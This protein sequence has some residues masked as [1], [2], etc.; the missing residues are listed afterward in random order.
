MA[1]TADEHSSGQP[2]ESVSELVALQRL[3]QSPNR[4]ST[5][6]LPVDDLIQP[7]TASPALPAQDTRTA[8][9][10]NTIDIPR[11]PV[12]P[13]PRGLAPQGPTIV[14]IR[15]PIYVTPLERLGETPEWID[16]P[17]CQRRTRTMVTKE[18]STSTT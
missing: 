10:G 11:H 9:S 7:L 13:L 2:E 1:V 4:T 6:A 18:D 16:C 3:R 17:F 14:P 8:E 15:N 5:P 12:P